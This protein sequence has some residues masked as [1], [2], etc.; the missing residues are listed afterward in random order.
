MKPLTNNVVPAQPG[1]ESLEPFSD[2]TDYDRSPIVA[3]IIQFETD[4]ADNYPVAIPVTTDGQRVTQAIRTPDGR[5]IRTQFD[6][7]F[8]DESEY[9]ARLLAEHHQRKSA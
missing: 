3:W 9:R 7:D 8:A 5:V 6:C 4:S 2:S 1:F